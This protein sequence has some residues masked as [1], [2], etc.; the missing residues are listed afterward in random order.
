MAT[1]DFGC[2]GFPRSGLSRRALLKVSAAGLLGLPRAAAVARPAAHA[3][4]RIYPAR[5]LIK[6]NLPGMTRPSSFC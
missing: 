1:D 5:N 4:A 2:D 6:P 3:K